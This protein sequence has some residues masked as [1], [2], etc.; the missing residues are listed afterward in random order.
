MKK[1]R[2]PK[3]NCKFKKIKTNSWF[4]AQYHYKDKAE[5][6]FI[7][8]QQEGTYTSN[9]T[10]QIYPTKEQKNILHHWFKL[11]DEM[12]NVTTAYIKKNIFKENKLVDIK[13][14]TYVNFR[15]LRSVLLRDIKD[16]IADTLLGTIKIPTHII[17]EA[18]HRCVS[19][20]KSAITKCSKGQIKNKKNAH[21]FEIRPLSDKRRYKMLTLDKTM[22]NNSMNSIC[23][24]SLGVMKSS[25]PFDV[26]TMANLRYD[27]VRRIYM[28]H[29]GEK[30]TRDINHTNK[31]SCGIDPGIRTFLTVYS[32]S[33]VVEIGKNINFDKYYKKIDKINSNFSKKS[34]LGSCRYKKAMT[35]IHDKISN[36]VKD[37]H[38]KVSHYLCANYNEIRLGKLGTKQIAS[39]SVEEGLYPK[40]KRLLYSLSH[41]KF[42][43]RLVHQANKYGI[44]L[45]VV[46]EYMTT[47]TCSGC[48]TDHK[49]IGK[50]K[51]FKCPNKKC[52]MIADRDVN[53]AK[54]ILKGV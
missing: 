39:N 32:D 8:H 43:E 34:F 35:R 4:G 21:P 45:K 22:I 5:F 46:S 12:Y 13:T 11:C 9:R 3:I 19:M 47:R 33:D 31:L 18:I 20:Y 44:N 27:S 42:R 40:T 30:H 17:D 28:L 2:I 48:G 24:N 37:M 38:Y 54:N 1:S 50:N 6:E 26:N 16:E 36:R 15:K 51:I 52:G 10:I 49:L 53:A 41:Y 7:L 23:F 25:Q 14:K 29:M